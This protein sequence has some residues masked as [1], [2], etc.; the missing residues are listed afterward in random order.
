MF[1]CP[2]SRVTRQ[3][4]CAL[5]VSVKI[6]QSQI[7]STMWCSRTSISHT[8]ATQHGSRRTQAM[9]TS[10]TWLSGI[11]NSPTS[12][13][14]F[15]SQLVFTVSRIV[16]HQ[17][18]RFQILRGR[19]FM[20]PLDIMLARACTALLLRLVRTSSFQ[21]SISRRWVV[22]RSSI[23]VRTLPMVSLHFGGSLFSGNTNSKIRT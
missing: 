9:G 7:I 15:T 23:Y 14:Q 22:V 3:E 12:T 10:R 13:S 18:Y 11:L 4:E 5:G 8:A 6:L 19:T 17:G 1:M 20:G 21:I 2:T 16:M